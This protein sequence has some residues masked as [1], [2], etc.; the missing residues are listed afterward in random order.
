MSADGKKLICCGSTE[1]LM[2]MRQAGEQREAHA[3]CIP[4]NRGQDEQE[5]AF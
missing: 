1:V 2:F 5:F 3:S 4:K